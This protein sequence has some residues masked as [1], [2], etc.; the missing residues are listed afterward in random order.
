MAKQ[1]TGGSPRVTGKRKAEQP[2]PKSESEGSVAGSVDSCA[3]TTRGAPGSRRSTRTVASGAPSASSTPSKPKPK[4]RKRPNTGAAAEP[5]TL[6]ASPSTPKV[7]PPRGLKRTDSL[8]SIPGASSSSNPAAPPA[9][10]IKVKLPA[11]RAVTPPTGTITIPRAPPKVKRAPMKS[12]DPSHTFLRR[13]IPSDCDAF[14]SSFVLQGANDEAINFEIDVVPGT[15]TAQLV[16]GHRSNEELEEFYAAS[17]DSSKTNRAVPVADLA[18]DWRSSEMGMIVDGALEADFAAAAYNT[19][20]FDANDPKPARVA[21]PYNPSVPKFDPARSDAD[22]SADAQNFQVEASKYVAW[23]SAEGARLECTFLVDLAA[24]TARR[25]A[26]V[27]RAT[28]HISLRAEQVRTYIDRHNFMISQHLSIIQ[29]L[30]EYSYILS[31]GPEHF[32]SERAPRRLPPSPLPTDVSQPSAAPV[33]SSPL[34]PSMS[35]AEEQ[36]AS[37]DCAATPAL[38]S[39][40]CPT[41][42]RRAASPAESAHSRTLG[43]IDAQPDPV[44]PYLDPEDALAFSNDEQDS[45][46]HSSDD[47]L[48]G[49]APVDKGKGREP[50]ANGDEGGESEPE[51]VPLSVLGEEEVPP[52]T[53]KGGSGKKAKKS[54]VKVK[55]KA[56]LILELPVDPESKALPPLLVP[57]DHEY[58]KHEFFGE[59][60]LLRNITGLYT[61]DNAPRGL[62]PYNGGGYTLSTR[63]RLEHCITGLED[64]GLSPSMVGPVVFVTR[65]KGCAE[66]WAPGWWCLRPRQG[67]ELHAKCIRCLALRKACTQ[68]DGYN[69]QVVDRRSLEINLKLFVEVLVTHGWVYTQVL[70]K[71]TFELMLCAALQARR[72]GPPSNAKE[73]PETVPLIL[74]GTPEEVREV[75]KT[76]VLE[77]LPG[78]LLGIEAMCPAGSSQDALRAVLAG[79]LDAVDKFGNFL[80]DEIDHI[81][82]SFMAA[83]SSGARG[84]G[85]GGSGVGSAGKDGDGDM[86]MVGGEPLCPAGFVPPPRLRE[87]RADAPSTPAALALIRR[88]RAVDWRIAGAQVRSSCAP[89]WFRSVGITATPGASIVL[90]CAQVV[91]PEVVRPTAVSCIAQAF[92]CCFVVPPSPELLSSG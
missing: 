17:I 13:P 12:L 10:S 33:S 50:G 51:V 9:V 31:V 2:E 72:Y 35:Q 4:P 20:R 24:W 88:V 57:C 92:S 34:T 82:R 85:S 78:V 86:M 79:M 39:P 43:S 62:T 21:H 87:S 52:G 15:V 28:K 46:G 36:P 18:G 63:P 80:R 7:G 68:L 8:P 90:T 58:H 89:Q 5:G 1:K 74:E 64:A 23:W 61:S 3:T 91:G 6:A 67:Y 48:A 66:C 65:G 44:G 38:P 69:F 30:G 27:D 16:R 81:D 56:D 59:G 42:D 32:F 84:S 47:E 83:N 76:E 40:F 54:K 45:E 22:V 53:T 49:S 71:N 75:V 11:K 55:P 73:K 37:R 77:V 60:A 19:V 29:S 25:Q 70:N 41:P 26:W 14:P